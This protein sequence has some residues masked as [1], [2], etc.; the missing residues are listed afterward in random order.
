MLLEEAACETDQAH[1]ANTAT[2]RADGKDLPDQFDDSFR[3][4][5]RVVPLMPVMLP[6]GPGQARDQAAC[7]PDRRTIAHHDRNFDGRIL[8]R[9]CSGRLPRDDDVDLEGDKLIGKRWQ[10]S[11]AAAPFALTGIRTRTRSAPST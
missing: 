6:P 9:C 11:W 5:R 10:A 8:C 2:R 1:C 7:R 3:R 4:A